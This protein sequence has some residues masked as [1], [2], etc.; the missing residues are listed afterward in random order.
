M[1]IL[2]NRLIS[3]LF[4][5]AGW[6]VVGVSWAQAMVLEVIPLGYRTADQVIPVIQPLL[7]PGGSLSGMRDKLV[8][9]TTAENLIEIR[10]VLASIDSAPRK[11]LISVRQDMQARRNA[12]GGKISGRIGNDHARVA[13]A[14]RTERGGGRIVVQR[15]DGHVSGHVFD[16]ASTLAERGTQTVQVLEGREAYVQIG[17]SVPVTQREVRRSEVGGRV[18]ER[19]VESSQYRDANTGFYVLPRVNG[20]RVYLEISP[21]RES[22]SRGAPGTVQTQRVVT[23]VSGHLGEWMEI[24][25]ISQAGGGQQSA[26]L[27]RATSNFSDQRSVWVKVETLR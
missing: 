3:R 6:L 19:V 17:Q 16:S 12:R 21:R 1:P 26:L 8:V 4:F 13:V 23:S 24:G 10:R 20:D 25:G 7:A 15:G 18:V 22:F 9:R 5:L 2:C 27:G 14:G 11:L